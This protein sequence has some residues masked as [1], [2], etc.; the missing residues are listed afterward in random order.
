MATGNDEKNRKFREQLLSA[1]KR[2]R[3][4][5]EVAPFPQYGSHVEAN[6]IGTILRKETIGGGL[7]VAFAAIAIIWANSPWAETYFAVRDFEF[8]IE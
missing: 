5:D 7:L 6:R 4:P 1:T 3:L 2:A 8:G